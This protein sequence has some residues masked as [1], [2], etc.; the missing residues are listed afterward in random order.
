MLGIS[1][2]TSERDR[3]PRALRVGQHE[4]ALELY[5]LLELR[6]PNNAR[7]PRR[8]GDLLRRMGRTSEAI[9]AYA[10]AVDSYAAQGFTARS[11]AM[12]KVVLSIDPSRTDVL[13]RA[14]PYR[15]RVTP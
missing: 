1:K 10:R 12:A 9:E 11:A 14:R 13:E 15:V 6:E 3:L 8:K 4:E 7:W 2:T 5:S